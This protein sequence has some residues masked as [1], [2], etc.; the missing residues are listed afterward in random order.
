MITKDISAIKRMLST[1]SRQP[2]EYAGDRLRNWQNAPHHKPKGVKVETHFKHFALSTVPEC[3]A[4]ERMPRKLSPL[5]FFPCVQLSKYREI[6]MSALP[7]GLGTV[8]V[9]SRPWCHS[10]DSGF[11]STWKYKSSE[12]A[13]VSATVSK[14]SS[15]M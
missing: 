8:L 4:H 9:G 7:M 15:G 6:S 10:H 11:A 14:D 3:P 13:E 1:L 2:E 12:V 5:S